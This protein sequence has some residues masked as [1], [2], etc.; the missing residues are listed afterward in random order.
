MFRFFEHRVPPTL[1]PPAGEPPQ[2]LT[3]FY[4]HF[5]RQAK[6][7]FIALFAAGLCVALLDSAVPVFIGHIVTLVSTHTPATLWTEAWP[8]LVGMAVVLLVLRPIAMVTQNLL[9]QNAIAANV[10][11]LVR[12]Q[13]HWHVVRQNWSF[14]QDDFAGRIANRVMQTAPSLRESI[15]LAINTVWYIVVYGTS[16]MILL[17]SADPRLAGP[18][19]VWAVGYVLLLRYFVPRLRDRARDISEIRSWL[20]G[21]IVDTYTNILTV[22]LFARAGTKTT[23]YVKPSTSIRVPS[24]GNSG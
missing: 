16:A 2:G 4:W 21:R 14:F 9:T 20:T 6:G 8:Q 13:S 1:P 15:V 7:L 22:K 11:N 17:V 5:A 12:W 3:A 10:T 24:T 23:M 19:A 18:L